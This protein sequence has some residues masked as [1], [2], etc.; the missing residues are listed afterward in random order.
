[1]NTGHNPKHTSRC[2]T[3][4]GLTSNDEGQAMTNKL[5]IIIADKLHEM[6]VIPKIIL[7]PSIQRLRPGRHGRSAG[8]WSWVLCEDGRMLSIGSQDPASVIAKGFEIRWCRGDLNLDRITN[9]VQDDLNNLC[10]H[11]DE[12]TQN[13]LAEERSTGDCKTLLTIDHPE[14]QKSLNDVPNE[15]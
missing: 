7:N 15:A 12:N 1:M 9:P 13:N 4:I 10:K 11:K 8:A 14:G 5:A 6:K 2:N 3:L